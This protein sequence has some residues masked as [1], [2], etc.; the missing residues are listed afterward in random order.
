[1]RRAVAAVALVPVIASASW[2]AA[3]PPIHPVRAADNAAHRYPDSYFDWWRLDVVDPKTGRWLMMDYQPYD[4]RFWISV[5]DGKRVHGSTEIAD[6]KGA[7]TLRRTENGWQVEIHD[8][9]SLRGHL[10]LVGRSGV[11][12]GPWHL[13]W[14]YAPGVNRWEHASLWWSAV[15]PA[16]RLDGWFES[17]D[18]YRV[19]F[20]GWRG[21]LG[22]TWGK[23]V[24]YSRAYQHWDLASKHTGPRESWLLQGLEP[25][26]GRD[27]DTTWR[28]PRD[29]AWQGVLV[30]ATARS[31]T[32]CRPRV[33]RRGWFTTYSSGWG[34][35]GPYPA[36]VTARCGSTSVTFGIWHADFKWGD[37]NRT[38]YWIGWGP[39][40]DRRGF[41][42]HILPAE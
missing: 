33:T 8:V 27:T 3:G 23:L 10:S 34:T 24:L 29:R 36:R 35:G 15:V 7:A 39:T 41:I 42:Q 25:R 18:G 28:R 32:V 40:P 30:H 6:P 26:P 1:M 9:P 16:G 31:V 21:N 13:G 4:G 14:Q 2:A 5:F 19:D 22:H 20:R 37:S 17:Y 11:T 38:H 12:A